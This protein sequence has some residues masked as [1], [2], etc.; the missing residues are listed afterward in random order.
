[1][2]PEEALKKYW[3]YEAFLPKQDSVIANV[4]KQKDTLAILPTGAGKS[5]CYQIPAVISK[6]IC[7]VVSPLLA[8]MQDQVVN[9]N[10]R[11]IKATYIKSKMLLNEVH[12]ELDN[13]QFGNYKLLYISPERLKRQ[14]I[15]EHVINLPISFVAV[16]EAHCISQWGHDFR[17]A[18]REISRLREFLPNLKFLALT[19]TAT[20]TVANDII[21]N[22]KLNSPYVLKDSFKKEQ[23]SILKKESSDKL[24]SIL[25]ILKEEKGSGII[26]VRRRQSAHDI[27]RFLNHHDITSAA[28]HAGVDQS[29]KNTTLQDW[30]ANKIQVVV[31]TTAFG[32]GID[33]PDVRFVIH[34][35]LPESLEN[36]YQEIG[37]AA[38]DRKP[39]KAILLYNQNDIIHLKNVHLKSIIT[40]DDV[41]LVYKKLLQ[42]FRIAFGEGE[43]F[44][45][46]LNFTKFCEKY[47]LNTHNAYQS[48][49]LLDKIDVIRLS[50]SFK[51][52]TKIQFKSNSKTLLNFIEKHKK[53]YQLVSTILRT[54]GGIFDHKLRIN[55][56]L[57]AHKVKL[58]EFEVVKQLKELSAQDLVEVESFKHDLSLVFLVPREDEASINPFKKIIIQNGEHKKDQI[59]AVIEFASENNECLQNK[60]LYYFGEVS[61]RPCGNCSNCNK[62]LKSEVSIKEE[63]LNLLKQ[64]KELN[65]QEI[66]SLLKLNENVVLD[67]LKALYIN[68][69]I[70]L[71]PKKKYTI[72]A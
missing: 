65:S 6:G 16:D 60:I 10:N 58:T 33:K 57:I 14:E 45:V 63:I 32:M 51:R 40:P 34:Y 54:Y 30:L 24:Y 7:L 21:E 46:D 29:K 37:R 66:I 68:H 3:G 42:Y 49:Q 36:Y 55:T 71:T 15:F 12:R 18:Y 17:P 20:S 13:C 8:L 53:Y 48:L 67:T 35:H 27:S 23:I 11:G 62:K 70:K 41:K 50:K 31:A 56:E 26:Y 28:F 61:S 1:M 19:A 4:L 43:F 25:N 5:I 9:L 47:K 59:K 69:K 2:T 72:N 22:L 52:T 38:R 64:Y 44:E 39:A